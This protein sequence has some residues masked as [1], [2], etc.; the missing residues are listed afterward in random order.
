MESLRGQT[1]RRWKQLSHINVVVMAPVVKNGAAIEGGLP[2]TTMPRARRESFAIWP[3]QASCSV[4]AGPKGMPRGDEEDEED[5]GGP[6]TT[7]TIAIK[8]RETI[9]YRH[10]PARP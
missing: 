1:G 8:Y 9:Q 3:S 2:A 6:T 4:A 5:D 7:A 10:P